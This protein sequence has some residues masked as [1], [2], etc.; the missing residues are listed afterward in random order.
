MGNIKDLI[1]MVP[2]MNRLA[3]DVSL[4]EDTFKPFVAIIHSMTPQ[5]RAHPAILNQSRRIRIAKGSGTPLQEVNRLLKQ[6]EGMCQMMKK[7]QQ[8]S[9]KDKMKLP[10]WVK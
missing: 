3:K 9:I 8:G 7:M 2:G 10:S 6:F 1:G 4:E 5:E